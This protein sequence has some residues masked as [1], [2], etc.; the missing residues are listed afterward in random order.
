MVLSTRKLLI[1]RNRLI[2]LSV[3]VVEKPFVP[4]H[5]EAETLISIA[6]AHKRLLTVF[7]S[8]ILMVFL[9]CRPLIVRQTDDGILIS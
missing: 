1:G 6:K 7:Q 9:F 4:T 8:M 3:V 2:E 5:R